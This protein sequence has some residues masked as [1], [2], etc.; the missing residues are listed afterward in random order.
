MTALALPH[1]RRGI[2]TTLHLQPPARRVE[3][4]PRRI[5]AS[6]EARAR[7]RAA[8][9]V[10]FLP[11]TGRWR[12]R[13]RG[14]LGEIVV[15]RAAVLSTAWYSV[16]LRSRSGIAV[17]GGDRQPTRLPARPRRGAL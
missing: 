11:R 4:L 17:D 13:L 9:A 15:H 8:D 16:C 10:R 5:R 12:G 6:A 2:T 3:R 7:H 1:G 14:M